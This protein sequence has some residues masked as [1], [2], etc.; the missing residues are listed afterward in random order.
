MQTLTNQGMA[1]PR[2]GLGTWPMRGAECQAAVESALAL[3]YRHIDT[4]AAYGNEDAVGAGIA[5]AGVPRGQ[6]H[7]TTKVWHDQLAPGGVAAAIERSLSALRLDYVDLYLIHWPARGMDLPRTLE[8][9]VRLREQGRARAI[10]VS[11]FPVALMRQAVEE[12]DAPIAC[13]QVEY[14]V[15]LD[16]SAVLAYARAHGIAVT[17]YSPLAKGSEL[18][19]IAELTAIARKHDATAAQVALAWLLGQDGVAAVPKAASRG[20]QAENLRALDVTLDAADREAIALL[21]KGRRLVAPSW[22]PAWD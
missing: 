16:Q 8:A 10:G 5:T 22:A 1:M 2:L 12:V 11:N 21:P 9:M 20:R 7:V 18:A 3:G 13:N 14:H 6:I 15:M 4:A 19:G 17:A